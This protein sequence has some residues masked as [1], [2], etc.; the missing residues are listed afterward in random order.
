MGIAMEI[1]QITKDS[2]PESLKGARVERINLRIGRLAAVVP[3]SLTFCF[4]VA[5]Q[6]TPV[7]GAVLNI[8][9]LPVEAACR[10]C[11]NRWEI[12]E[13]VF[14]C[15]VCRSGSVE[16]L[17]GRELDIVSIEIEEDH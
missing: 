10:D 1:V 6:G 8:E 7:E 15:P 17:S 16:V 2:I 14:W 12:E 5:S 4:A 11:G 3:D 13:T 9:H